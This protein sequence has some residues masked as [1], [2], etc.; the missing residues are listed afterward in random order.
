MATT[1]TI[2][3]HDG[4]GNIV[5]TYQKGEG[6]DTVTVTSTTDNRGIDRQQEVSFVVVDGAIR[7]TIAASGSVVIRTSGGVPLTCL[8][9]AMKVTVTIVQPTGKRILLS[10]NGYKIVA[11]YGLVLR[12]NPQI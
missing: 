7:H 5:L 1:I 6:N 10:S 9:D 8:D 2:P 12:V 11:R 3:W 4:N